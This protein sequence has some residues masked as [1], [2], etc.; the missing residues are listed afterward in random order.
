MASKLKYHSFSVA[1]LSI[2]FDNNSSGLA[3]SGAVSFTYKKHLFSLGLSAGSE[4]I[5]I[6]R[7]ANNFEQI[8]LLYGKELKLSRTLFLDLHTGAG[9]FS[10]SA[11]A[12]NPNKLGEERATTM[13]FPIKTTFR[14]LIGKKISLGLQFQANINSVRT[15]NKTYLW[16]CFIL[17][18]VIKKKLS[19]KSR[20]GLLS[21][22]TV[23]S[24]F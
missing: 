3:L 18:T 10:L 8:N 13:G 23:T 21:F 5:I 4:F 7:Y 12:I 19:L 15:K 17:F 6:G 24:N 14:V 16:L 11:T 1:P 20:D 22:F 9:Y 2:Y